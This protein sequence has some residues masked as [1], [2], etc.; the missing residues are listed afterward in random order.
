MAYKSF[1]IICVSVNSVYFKILIG[2][3]NLNKFIMTSGLNTTDESPAQYVFNNNN[4]NIWTYYQR[5]VENILYLYSYSEYSLAI[6]LRARLIS[7]N[8]R[9]WTEMEEQHNMI[10]RRAILDYSDY[11]TPLRPYYSLGRAYQTQCIDIVNHETV[12]EV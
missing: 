10:D 5:D 12:F 3:Q 6:M 9:T 1:K 4:N 8:Q 2:T 7:T 11:K